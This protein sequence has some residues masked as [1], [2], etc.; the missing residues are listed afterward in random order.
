MFSKIFSKKSKRLVK[1]SLI[2]ISNS[3]KELIIAPQ[4]KDKSGVLIEQEE[5][6]V[7][8]YP[9]DH[10]KLGYEL[11]RCLNLFFYK[12]EIIRPEKA[13][14]WPAYKHSRYKTMKAFKK[15]NVRIS[16]K[17]LNTSNLYL[18]I[19]GDPY[20]KSL[21]TINSIVPCYLDGKLDD[22]GAKELGSTID[23]VYQACLNKSFN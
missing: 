8:E 15:E 6:F 4:F 2:Y 13:S 23:L 5:C 10:V 14:D 21:L 12:N 18:E 7:Y 19:I 22:K 1:S 9:I 3:K 11:F 17:S 16:V 20:E